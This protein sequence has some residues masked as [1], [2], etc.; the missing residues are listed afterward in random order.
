M[1]AVASAR[2]GGNANVESGMDFSSEVF[3]EMAEFISTLEL[4]LV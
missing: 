4:L 3:A 1:A 2:R